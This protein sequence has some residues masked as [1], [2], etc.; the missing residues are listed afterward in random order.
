MPRME[1]SSALRH[2]LVRRGERI[3]RATSSAELGQAYVRLMLDTWTRTL[4]PGPNGIFATTGDIPAMWLRDSS[5]QMRPWLALADE[6]PEVAEVLR[7]VCLMQWRMIRHD[8]YAN[9]FN[10]GPVGGTHHLLDLHMLTSR[11]DPWIWERKYE[12]DSLAL[13]LLLAHQIQQATGSTEHL[14]W[15]VHSGFA[16]VVDLWRREQDHATSRY[17]FIRLP[18]VVARRHADTL[19]RWGR[20]S[21]VGRTRMTWQGFRPSDDATR[22]GYNIPAQLLAVHVL[23]LGAQWCDRLWHDQPLGARARD[24]AEQIA[25]GVAEHGTLPDGSWA[26]EVDGLGGVLAADDANLPS[27]LGLPLLTDIARDDPRYLATRARILSAANPWWHTGR[28]ASG[29]GSPHTPG[30]RVWPIA[31]AVQGLTETNREEALALARLIASTTAGTGMVHESFH[32]DDPHRFTRGWF[33]W[34]NMMFCELLDRLADWP[35]SGTPSSRTEKAD[36]DRIAGMDTGQGKPV[37]GQ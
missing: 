7:G 31:L 9:A 15:G 27:L 13:P 23:R 12:L 36:A 19:P 20:G 24:L 21:P 10:H 37:A 11:A 30:P 5:A 32:V 14:D 34:A 8:P 22:Y 35:A 17:R 2:A 3:A 1:A 4:H 18:A 6:L 25:T 16:D 26:Y 28:V 33:S 29:I